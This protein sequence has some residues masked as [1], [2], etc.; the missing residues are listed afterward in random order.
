[1][2]ADKQISKIEKI[3][4]S[5]GF[6]RGNLLAEI[7]R[8]DHKFSHD[9]SILLNFHG[10][11]QQKTRNYGLFKTAAN[12]QIPTPPALM[13][14]GRIAGGRLTAKQWVIWNNIADDYATRGLR[15][16]SRQNIQV[17]GICKGDITKVIGQLADSLQTTQGSCGDVVH[18][19][20]LSVNP[21]GDPM[22]AELMPLA[23][24]LSEHFKVSSGSYFDIFLNGVA[25]PNHTG[26][27]S[28]YGKSYLPRKFRI[29]LT[30]E[31]NNNVDVYAQ[32]LALVAKFSS[33]IQLLGFHV[34]LGGGL[35]LSFRDQTTYSQ[36]A[37][38]VGFIR[39]QELL[40]FCEAVVTCHRDFSNRQQRT[41]ARL[42]YTINKVG[43]NAF[44]A[45]VEKRSGT[46]LCDASLPKWQTPNYLG[47]H[48]HAN[49]SLS[50]G[51][52]I[53][54]GRIANSADHRLKACLRKVVEGYAASLQITPQQDLVL[55][56]LDP[57]DKSE[58]IRIFDSYG[59]TAIT[60]GGVYDTAMSCVAFP[61][62]KMAFAESERY[63][64][65]LLAKV[66]ELLASYGKS[67][68]APTIR[69]SGCP[70]GCVRPCIAEIGI[71]GQAYDSYA[72][73]FGGAKEGDRLAVLVA[74][75][76]DISSILEA[77]AKAFRLWQAAGKTHERFGDFAHRIG[78][79]KIL[80]RP[81]LAH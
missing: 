33:K 49:G 10:L 23:A 80:Q 24:K 66:E 18:N 36:L 68:L 53:L 75:G 15:L 9:S 30:V 32:D 6:L 28:I 55:M 27:E 52:H 26:E 45:E 40:A 29:A 35:G 76:L 12:K 14:R 38:H 21:S 1:M 47:W 8:N 77:M 48:Q 41:H 74:Q 65:S 72:L 13:L 17:H 34:L 56:E 46:R 19:I 25:V 22:L 42:K 57:K 4:L 67:H 5:S 20:C 39:P 16:T 2:V 11:H 78:A 71:I 73:Y 79:T 51:I 63:S 7:S 59:I 60:P 81:K 44:T 37:R 70:N 50:L 3:K 43:W 54:A 61:T 69:I 58:I 62:C 31:G 64:S